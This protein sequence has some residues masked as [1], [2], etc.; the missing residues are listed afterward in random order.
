MKG[1]AMLIVQFK[2]GEDVERS[3][4][5][6]YNEL[7]KNMDRMPQGVTLPLIKSRAIDDVP[8]LGV[9]L[10]SD[11][12]SDFDLRQQGEVLTNEIKKI[13]DI[14]DVKIIGGRSRVVNVVLDK[15][16]MAESKVDFLSIAKQIQGG[17][18]QLMS[19]SL[20]KNDTSFAVETGNFLSNREE[21]ANLIVGVNQQQPVYL[22]QIATI[23]DGAAAPSQYVTFGYGRADAKNQQAFHSDYQAI[24][25][26]V[27]KK[28]GP[29]PCTCRSRF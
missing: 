25:L 11:S 26:S 21:I 28:K 23:S 5:K 22:R 14:A 9:T 17:N 29:M 1:Q 13:P 27:A 24:T 10:W 3:L 15:D 7:M 2:V 16:K 6:L 18:A 4:V 19:G 12:T 20:V 8:V